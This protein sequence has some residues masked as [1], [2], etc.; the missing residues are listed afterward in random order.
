[1][2]FNGLPYEKA[3]PDPFPKMRRTKVHGAAAPCGSERVKTHELADVWGYQKQ[4]GW[5]HPYSCDWALDTF[6][7]ILFTGLPYVRETLKRS[8]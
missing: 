6:L 4:L 1:M 8:P 7:Y 2:P 5:V 3:V